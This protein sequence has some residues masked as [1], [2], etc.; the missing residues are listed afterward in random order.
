MTAHRLLGLLPLG[1]D[2][3]ILS[4]ILKGT[5]GH[6]NSGGK[7]KWR[8]MGLE[9]NVYVLRMDTSTFPSGAHG[10]PWRAE[11]CCDFPGIYIFFPLVAFEEHWKMLGA[12]FR[13]CK[14]GDLTWSDE[15]RL[16][17]LQTANPRFIAN[18]E[19]FVSS[20]QKS[21]CSSKSII[22]LFPFTD[23]ST[24]RLGNLIAG[25]IFSF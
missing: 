20:V 10:H 4:V 15:K 12:A 19:G 11:A 17:V 22:D 13:D 23:T 8:E 1:G 14:T 9:S 16:K 25:C 18:T 21:R 2:L 7:Y 24:F 6:V 3:L 5:V